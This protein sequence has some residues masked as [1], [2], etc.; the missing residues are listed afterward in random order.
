MESLGALNLFSEP[1]HRPFTFQAGAPAALLVHGFPGTPA[2]MRPLADRLHDQGWT[3]EGLL[4]P[5]FGPEIDTLFNR[6]YTEWQSA[7]VT[8]INGLRAR[9]DP[10]VLIG[11][12]LGGALA[13]SAAAASP[14]DRL[15]L[16]APFWRLGSGVQGLIWRLVGVIFPVFQPFRKVDFSS[17]QLRRAVLGLFPDLDLDNPANQEILR[18][19]RVPTR[20]VEQVRQVG[21]AAWRAAPQVV[22]PTLIVQGDQDETVRLAYTRKLRAR[23]PGPVHYTEV[24]AGHALLDPE[25]GEWERVSGAVLDYLTPIRT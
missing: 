24:S 16:L 12:S 21:Q 5:G 25:E 9:H 10:V 17:A 11:F 22:S 8:A 4:L 19:L 3:V 13:I 6:R 2:E 1:E 14:V 7:V 15:V 18:G 23:I 20:L